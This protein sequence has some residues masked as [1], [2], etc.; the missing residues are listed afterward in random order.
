MNLFL[1]RTP[2]QLF[3]CQ[4]ARRRFHHGECNVLWAIYRKEV[5]RRQMLRVCDGHWQEVNCFHLNWV[6]RNFPK[7]WVLAHRGLLAEVDVFYTGFSKRLARAV[8]QCAKPNHATIVDDG[9]D[10]LVTNR[11]LGHRSKVTYFTC[12]HREDRDEILND[13]QAFRSHLQSK[14][15][16]SGGIAF[17]GSPV[18]P[19]D[20]LDAKVFVGLMEQVRA[21][22]ENESIIYYA[23]RYENPVQLQYWMK[24]LDIEVR[25]PDTILECLLAEAS[26]L[27][28]EL[29]TFHSTAIDTL[30]LIYHLPQRVFA[31][32]SEI[33]TENRRHTYLAIMASFRDRGVPVTE[34]NSARSR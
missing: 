20:I 19:R 13:Y 15:K 21:H 9:N 12:F 23:H 32:P 6:L 17:I 4:E 26:T 30:H 29:A 8:V 11:T 2:L 16:A 3:N 14:S 7:L 34:I 22:Y 33:V 28:R 27:P 24:P 10:A 31:F 5:D 25:S 18:Y 1:A